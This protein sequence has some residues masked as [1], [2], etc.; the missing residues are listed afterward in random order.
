MV[1]HLQHYLFCRSQWKQQL[2]Q[3]SELQLRIQYLSPPKQASTHL[4]LIDKESHHIDC[5]LHLNH[6]AKCRKLK[7]ILLFMG[8]V[9]QCVW[10]VVSR[11]ENKLPI[12]GGVV[13]LPNVLGVVTVSVQ[14]SSLEIL[15]VVISVM[16]VQFT[17]VV[18]DDVLPNWQAEQDEIKAEQADHFVPLNTHFLET[19]TL[20]IYQ[21]QCC[22][23]PGKYCGLIHKAGCYC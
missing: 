6:M 11:S 1:Q 9:C 8:I 21:L 17:S 13:V 16:M 23:F 22:H 18:L 10:N 4:S 20:Q 14:F 12:C 3:G 7:C 15:F 19:I 2:Q 5:H